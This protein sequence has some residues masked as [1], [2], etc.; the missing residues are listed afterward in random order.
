MDDLDQQWR[1][2]GAT[3]SDKTARKEF[4]LTQ[5][6]IVDAIRSGKLHSRVS[7]MHGNPWFRLLRCEVEDLVLAIRGRG[8]LEERKATVE[9]AH[10]DSELRRLRAELTKLE[11]R[12]AE[13]ATRSPRGDDG[14]GVT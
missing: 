1:R 4:G 3:L 13:L 12:R 9:L 7:S 11:K 10:I 14:D 2:K 8:F 6:E 5:D